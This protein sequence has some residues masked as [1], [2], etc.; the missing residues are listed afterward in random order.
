MN[1]E[2]TVCLLPANDAEAVLIRD[3][4]RK[5]G[6]RVIESDQPHGATLDRMKGIVEEIKGLGA[7][8]IV[9]VE[10]P[11]LATEERLRQAGVEVKII[12]HHH[13]TGLD[14]AHDPQTGAPLPSSLEQT[15]VF[16]EL[17][18][19]KLSLLGFN[20]RFVHAIGILD[21]GYIWALLREGFTWEEMTEVFRY[22][23]ILL[24]SVKSM[25]DE[26]ERMEIAKRAWS[27]RKEWNGYYIVEDS[28]LHSLRARVSRI[29]AFSERKPVPLIVVEH[30][31]DFIYVQESDA[32]MK[33]FKTFGGFTFG[34][35]H[36]WGHK[37]E[38]GK[39]RVTLKDVQ[40]ALLD[41]KT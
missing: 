1:I 29:A 37:N 40:Q 41:G 12:D 32:G 17:T 14:R 8:T 36:G 19:E 39:Q 25:K 10:M 3:I 30:G 2:T 21:R 23:D 5:V 4:L 9:V 22:H 20:P 15:L 34:M 6:V 27:D 26:A 13:Y 16:F 11:G 28:S 7:K 33:L 31:R 38:P 24:G 18:D 35:D